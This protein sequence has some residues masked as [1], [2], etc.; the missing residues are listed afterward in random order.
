M[1][2]LHAAERGPALLQLG[3]LPALGDHAAV[4]DFRDGGDLL[5]AEIGAGGRDHAETPVLDA[6]RSDERAA[7]GVEGED[8]AASRAGEGERSAKDRG[9]R[10]RRPASVSRGPAGAHPAQAAGRIA[11]HEGVV[12]DVAGD[13][14]AGA[15]GREPADSGAGDDDGSGADG[16]AVAQARSG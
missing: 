4:Q 1:A 3:D 14:R 9:R 13:D 11:G 15:D 8:A 12:G 7:F 5:G 10:R 16:A 6:G 2:C